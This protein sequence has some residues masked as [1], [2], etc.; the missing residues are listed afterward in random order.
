MQHFSKNNISARTITR[1]P[2]IVEIFGFKFSIHLESHLFQHFLY[3]YMLIFFFCCSSFY[4]SLLSHS[5]FL[6]CSTSFF[7]NTC[8][9]MS[10][11]CTSE[12]N[13]V[14]VIRSSVKNVSCHISSV[15]C[16]VFINCTRIKSDLKEK[17]I[18]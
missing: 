6:F 16:V 1:I 14:A 11:C 10:E 15:Q 12:K 18:R 8:M 17:V 9:E 4:Q 3:P 5:F 13:S 7:V 2:S